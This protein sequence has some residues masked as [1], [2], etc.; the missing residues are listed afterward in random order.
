MSDEAPAFAIPE[1]DL[2]GNL[3]GGLYDGESEPEAPAKPPSSPTAGSR[4]VRPNSGMF[5]RMTLTDFANSVNWTN[6]NVEPNATSPAPAVLGRL[7]LAAFAGAINWTN[8]PLAA[9]ASL[10]PVEQTQTLDGFLS[11]FNWD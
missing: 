2:I 11:E 1:F 10:A 8:A 5:G 4:K 9:E 7:T 3:L 6:A